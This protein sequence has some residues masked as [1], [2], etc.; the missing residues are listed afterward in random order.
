MSLTEQQPGQALITVEVVCA[1]PHRQDVVQ[2]E[3][4]T[5]ACIAQVIALAGLN[6]ET[7]GVAIGDHN[8]GVFGQ[9]RKLNDRVRAGDR[10]EIYRALELDPMEAR[11]L[12]AQAQ[13]D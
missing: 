5:G 4:E 9:P 6:S 8:V 3:I 2:L 1:W 7:A 10:V 13:S 12:R 11:R